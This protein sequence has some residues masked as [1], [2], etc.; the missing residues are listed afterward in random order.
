MSSRHSRPRRC[1]PGS[2]LP[3]FALT[4]LFLAVAGATAHGQQARVDVLR[5]GTTVTLTGSAE[6]PR[7]KAGLETLRSFIKDETGLN[8]EVLRQT[9]W[10]ELADK[11]AKGQLQL[12][13][14]PGYEFAWAQEK[15]ADLKPLALAVNLYRYPVAHVVA[16][17]DSAAKDFASL[18]GQSLCLPATNQHFLRLFV[19]RQSDAAGKKAEAFFSTITSPDNVEDGLDDVVDGKVQ[20]AVVDQAAFERYKRRKPGRFNQ[21]KVVARSQPFPPGV[22]AY[23]GS[24]LDEATLRRLKGALLGAARKEKGETLL[25]LSRL[26][27]FE[28]VPDDFGRVLADTRKAYPPPDVKAK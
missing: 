13:V 26:T 28:T 6:G 18:Q 25:T 22:V 12:A 17:R 15:H 4:A 5:I 21:L 3:A 19:E 10:Q 23:H 8:N 24:A 1:R 14:F 7:E 2:L 9:N 11:M 20:A 16:A 27:G